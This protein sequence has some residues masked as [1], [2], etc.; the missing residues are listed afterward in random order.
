MF[1]TSAIAVLAVLLTHNHLT[2]AA[3]IVIPIAGAGAATL[4]ELVTPD[5]KDTVTCPTA[6]MLVM[7]P[8]M[9]LFGG[10]V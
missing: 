9:A 7:I 1:I 4:V 8:L 2:I 5:G 6:A 10:F 3:Y